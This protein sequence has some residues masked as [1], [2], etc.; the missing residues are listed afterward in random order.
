MFCIFSSLWKRLTWE[1]IF[2]AGYLQNYDCQTYRN[3]WIHRQ[4]GSLEAQMVQIQLSE[5]I[6]S[7]LASKV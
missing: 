7:E 1:A 4:T 6:L 2:E 3:W 5:Q